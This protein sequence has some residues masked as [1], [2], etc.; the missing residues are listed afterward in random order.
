MHYHT[1]FNVHSIKIKMAPTVFCWRH[2]SSVPVT[3]EISK[4]LVEDLERIVALNCAITI[5][6]LQI[7]RG[8]S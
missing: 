7:K 8:F 3:E 1:V 6:S 2:F 5:D 4:H